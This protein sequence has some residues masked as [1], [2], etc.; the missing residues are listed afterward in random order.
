[1]IT[2]LPFGHGRRN[3]PFPLGR[4]ARMDPGAGTIAWPV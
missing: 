3:R 2:D 4:M 1:V